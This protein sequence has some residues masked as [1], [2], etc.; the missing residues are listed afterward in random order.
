M[1]ASPVQDFILRDEQNLRT[2][3]AVAVAWPETRKRIANEF[4][5]R[6]GAKLQAEL[7]G[8]I[9]APW[10]Q[11]FEHGY[12]SFFVEK[13]SWSGEYGITLQADYHGGRMMFGVER[14]NKII[15]DRP[16]SPE[17]LEAVRPLF[18]SVR[19]KPWWDAQV[20]MRVPASDWTSPEV[21]WRMH[22]DPSFLN[23]VA[24][25]MLAIA[26]AT[27]SIIDRLTKKK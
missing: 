22:T 4:L 14:E 5:G 24:D 6:F 7:P 15:A 20:P 12:A 18:P 17:V 13:K 21:L 27:E 8:W 19:T 9:S 2:A 11:F 10:E 16:L 3:A 26:K 1:S 25:Q 23:S